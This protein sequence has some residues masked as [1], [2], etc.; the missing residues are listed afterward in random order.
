MAV[1]ELEVFAFGELGCGLGK[2][3]N[4]IE[5]GKLCFEVVARTPE[6]ADGFDAYAACGP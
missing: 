3:I 4:G 5:Q 1:D 6:C 2:A